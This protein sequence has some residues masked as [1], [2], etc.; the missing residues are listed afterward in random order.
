MNNNTQIPRQKQL[1]PGYQHNGISTYRWNHP[2]RGW[3]P[4]M[5][6]YFPERPEIRQT[7]SY[8]IVGTSHVLT[9]EQVRNAIGNG[10]IVPATLPMF[11]AV[12]TMDRV[13][14]NRIN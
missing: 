10:I 13:N 8:V 3:V 7:A 9:P 2:Q 6:E 4:L 5:L 1:Q 14:R 12:Q 11:W